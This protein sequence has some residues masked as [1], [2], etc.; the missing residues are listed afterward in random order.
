MKQCDVIVMVGL[1][2]GML[3][4][5]GILRGG[6]GAAVPWNSTTFRSWN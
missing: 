4:G 1:M 3:H 5:A 6:T 2:L